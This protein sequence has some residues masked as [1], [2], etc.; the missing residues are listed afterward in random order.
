[1]KLAARLE[2]AMLVLEDVSK[3]TG[4]ERVPTN[5][6]WVA[7]N[8]EIRCIRQALN[9]YY[10]GGDNT[11]KVRMGFVTNS[12]STSYLLVGITDGDIIDQIAHAIK[13]VLPESDDIPCDIDTF[14]DTYDEYLDY[15]QAIRS[16]LESSDLTMAIWLDDGEPPQM[17]GCEAHSLFMKNMTFDEI[18]QRF[19][20]II[21][22]HYDIDISP[23]KVSLEIVETSY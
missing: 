19:I 13:P 10:D 4:K 11:V 21:K 18:K 12:S 22:E 3:T 7:I 16:K 6:Q 1:M 15:W 14:Q 23:D 8:Q 2:S 9:R 17:I 5:Y 20:T